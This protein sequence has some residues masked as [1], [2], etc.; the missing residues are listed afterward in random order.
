M[1][2]HPAD[3]YHDGDLLRSTSAS[4]RM[5]RILVDKTIDFVENRSHLLDDGRESSGSAGQR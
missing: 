2:D 1:P 3:A 5:I 4:M